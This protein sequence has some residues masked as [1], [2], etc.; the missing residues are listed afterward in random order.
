MSYHINFMLRK[1]TKCKELGFRVFSRKWTI[2]TE[3]GPGIV[4][5]VTLKL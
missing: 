1:G 3:T 2:N 4:L 5:I